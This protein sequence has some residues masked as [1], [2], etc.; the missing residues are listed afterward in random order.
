TVAGR[1]GDWTGV[2][3]AWREWV[4]DHPRDVDAWERLGYAATRGERP[5]AARTALRRALALDSLSP[6]TWINLAGAERHLGEARRPS[7]DPVAHFAAAAAA[8]DRAF[9]LDSTAAQ[10]AFLMHEYGGVLYLAGRRADAL[11]LY[12][13]LAA[14]GAPPAQGNA[15]RSLAWIAFADGTPAVA[16]AE[17][18][19]A[20]EMHAT[21]HEVLSEARDH[22]LRAA[23]LDAMGDSAAARAA[24]ARAAALT[25]RQRLPATFIGWLGA[26]LVRHGELAQARALLATLATPDDGSPSRTNARDLLAGTLAAAERRDAEAESSLAA[27]A[28]YAPQELI[29]LDA[30]AWAAWTRATRASGAARA[31]ALDSAA[32]RY[33]RLGDGRAFGWEGALGWITAPYWLGRVEEE[34]SRPD[35]ARRAYAE[36]LA[37]QPGPRADERPASWVVRD[38]R[39]R[40]ASPSTTR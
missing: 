22:L 37:R 35:A 33:A 36:F 20:A 5:D 28:A 30:Q 2:E 38:A 24:L 6:T 15:H 17:L 14:E 21:L 29:A 34:R 8:Y 32:Q 27:A 9:S 25:A 16:E 26:A 19:R 1:R 11:A 23:A 40:L 18:A 39:R 10:R 4:A 31:L 13:R 12:R 3:A 7:S